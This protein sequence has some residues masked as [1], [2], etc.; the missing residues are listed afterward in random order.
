MRTAVIIPSI[1]RMSLLDRCLSSLLTGR[2]R[3]DEIIVVFQ[4][5][6][7]PAQSTEITDRYPNVTVIW[8]ARVGASAARN[9][10]ACSS[11]AEL[12]LFLDDDCEADA[13]WVATYAE[14]FRDD[15]SL[16]I[17]G[18][19]VLLDKNDASADIQLG[20]QDD[21]TPRRVT[22]R[23]NPVGTLD[24]GGNLAVRRSAFMKMGGFDEGLGPGTP[25]Q[26]AE[27]TDFI[28]R[29]MC[30]GIEMAYLPDA[31]VFHAQWRELSD[32]AL[33]EQGYGIGLGAFVAGHARRGD[34]YALSLAGRLMWHL[35][36]KPLARGLVRRRAPDI[37]SG[38]RYLACIPWGFARGI[39][40]DRQLIEES[41]ESRNTLIAM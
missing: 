37:R 36:G 39:A 32:A 24:R 38:L 12:L 13:D 40:R 20:I 4:G 25:C 18:G 6:P 2:S 23:R 33:V 22:G 26:A 34:L 7:N 41:G 5:Q 3:P 28:Y 8:S 31:I 14:R 10:G 9:A 16:D 27:D 19:R 17:A 11:D 21:Q 1:G 35:G 30:A 15:P 29:A